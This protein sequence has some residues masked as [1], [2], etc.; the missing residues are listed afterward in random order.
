MDRKDY[1]KA[2]RYLNPPTEVPNEEQIKAAI[3]EIESRLAEKAMNMTVNLSVKEG[4]T[5]AV[6]MLRRRQKDYA[7]IENLSTARARAIAA[8]AADFLNGECSEAI[9]CHVPVRRF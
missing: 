4:Y 9:L 1:F 7:G 6:E 3:A 2:A 5:K 8:L